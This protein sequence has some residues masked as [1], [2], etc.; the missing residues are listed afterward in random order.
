MAIPEYLKG[1]VL[2]FDTETAVLGDH[3]VEIGFSLFHNAVL[4]REWNTFVKPTVLIDPE[5]SAV[6]KITDADVENSPTFKEL[7]SWIYNILNTYGIH[8]AYNYEY[9]RGVLQKE[10]NRCGMLFPVKP[11]VDPLILFKKWNKF[12]RGKKLVDATSKYGIQY[13]GAHRAM[14]DATATG[15]L[16][17]KMA[18]VRNDFPKALPIYIKNQREWL[19]EQYIDFA[20]YR[21][22]KGQEPIN[23]PE[24]SFYEVSL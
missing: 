9:D 19:E 17:F 6:H 3:I 10:F 21:K 20:A 1:F 22:L 12:N 4:V 16:L 15:K 18:A 14:N 11:M 24:F 2:L 5:A 13:V 8:V 23:V 7:S